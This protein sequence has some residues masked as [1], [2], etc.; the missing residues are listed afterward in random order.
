MTLLVQ[1]PR[2]PLHRPLDSVRSPA[3]LTLACYSQ[4][5]SHPV[6]HCTRS[7]AR[8]GCVV[9]LLHDINDVLMELAKTLSYARLERASTLVFSMFMTSWV[10]LR[11]W[12]YPTFVIHSTL[13]E[14]QQALGFRP[15]FHA[16]LNCL[17]C[18]LY[19]FHVY[20]FCL[21]VRIAFKKLTTG[22]LQD[23]RES[24]S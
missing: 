24:E 12:A 1:R 11:I 17:L 4:S 22:R 19:V 20:W 21:I 8:A 7:Y 9:M 10:V 23:V 2:G 15:P 16:L 13:F 18:V 3:D 14:S 5:L 6:A